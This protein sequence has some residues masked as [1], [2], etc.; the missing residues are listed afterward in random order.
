MRSDDELKQLY[1][2]YLMR[3][4]SMY[5]IYNPDRDGMTDRDITNQLLGVAFAYGRMLGLGMSRI[6]LD[7]KRAT[8]KVEDQMLRAKKISH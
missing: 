7:A 6:R 8:T 1:N 4:A 5:Q 2:Q 3:F